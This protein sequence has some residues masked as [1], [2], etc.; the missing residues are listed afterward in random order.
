MWLFS[1]LRAVAREDGTHSEDGSSEY[2]ELS[3]E[4]QDRVMNLSGRWSDE[5]CNAEGDGSD[6]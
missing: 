3:D 2:E 5:P 6:E 4:I 1:V